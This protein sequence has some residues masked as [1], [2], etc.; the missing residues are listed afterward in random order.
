MAEIH[1]A[2]HEAGHFVA[3]CWLVPHLRRFDLSITSPESGVDGYSGMEAL[4][5]LDDAAEVENVIVVYHAGAAA[6]LRLDPSRQDEVRL[7]ARGDDA[8]VASYR[9]TARRT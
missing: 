7:G 2:Y 4:I 9:T 1:I 8:A 6:E 3:S 5:T